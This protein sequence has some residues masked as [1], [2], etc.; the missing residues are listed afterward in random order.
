MTF[1]LFEN[2]EGSIEPWGSFCFSIPLKLELLS[3]GHDK[4]LYGVLSHLQFEGG[5]MIV[6][7]ATASTGLGSS[8][9]Y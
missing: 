5:A 3:F 9:R 6:A 4:L 7:E 8:I 1:I 2:M